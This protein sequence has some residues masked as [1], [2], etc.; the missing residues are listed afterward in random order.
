MLSDRE[1]AIARHIGA[2]TVAQKAILNDP[3]LAEEDRKWLNPT[4]QIED[5]KGCLADAAAEREDC[6][7]VERSHA[8]ARGLL[9][10]HAS[11]RTA[12]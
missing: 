9:P 4:D 10:R 11:S 1:K 6:E 8:I 7:A 2:L 5:G 12:P 3:D